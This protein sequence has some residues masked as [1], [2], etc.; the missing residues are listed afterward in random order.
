MACDPLQLVVMGVSGCGKTTVATA[1][2]GA[3]SL[4]M[5]DGDDLHLPQSVAKM[6]AGE[7]LQDSDRW[8]WLERIG[9]YLANT[10]A[11]TPGRVVACSALRRVYRDHLRQ[12]APQVRFLFLD[13]SQ[14]LIRQRLALRTGHYMHPDLLDSQFQTLERPGPEEPDVINLSVAESMDQ[15]LGRAVHAVRQL[16]RDGQ[17]APFNAVVTP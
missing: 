1:L 16:T 12:F 9:H 6:R 10:P 13:G 2:A 7:A 15:M 14:D 3:L 17:A 5:V 8:P 11:N 4:E